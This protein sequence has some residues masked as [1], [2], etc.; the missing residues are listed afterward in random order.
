MTSL[1]ENS[2]GL[3]MPLRA[4]SIIPLEVIAPMIM[5]IEAI[6]RMIFRGAAFEPNAE[7]RKLT[8]SLVTPT[9]SPDTAS[10]ARMIRITV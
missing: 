1:N 8:A 9:N 3:N 7:L 2:D 6:R 5:P 10:A 4:T